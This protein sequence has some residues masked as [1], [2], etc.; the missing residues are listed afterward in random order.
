MY[1][2]FKLY[3]GRKRLQDWFQFHIYAYN[4]IG[5]NFSI[6]GYGFAF[7]FDRNDIIRKKDKKNKK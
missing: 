4:Q 7:Y 1:F 3:K 2:Y 6:I 5:F